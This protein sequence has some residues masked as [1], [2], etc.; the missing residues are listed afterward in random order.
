MLSTDTA[1]RTLFLDSDDL[2]SM[3]SFIKKK[4]DR[5]SFTLVNKGKRRVSESYPSWRR[6][7]FWVDTQDVYLPYWEPTPKGW[8]ASKSAIAMM[9]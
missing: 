3:F 1:A 8:V 7:K 5:Q 9:L 6:C 2:L 4:S